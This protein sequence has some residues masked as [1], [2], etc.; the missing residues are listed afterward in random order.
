M[1]RILVVEDDFASRRMMRKKLSEYGE[2]DL[3]VDGQEGVDAFRNALSDGSACDL[4]FLNVMMPHM[5][6]HEALRLM[7]KAEAASGVHTKD[8]TRILMRTALEDP[9]NVV[10]AYFKGGV[11]VC[12]VKPVDRLVLHSELDTFGRVPFQLGARAA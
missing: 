3:T 1:I 2:D 8:E 9:H 11:T 7:R 10:D 4:V 5:D 6:G 12:L